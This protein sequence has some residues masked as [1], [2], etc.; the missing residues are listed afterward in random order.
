MLKAV[1]DFRAT[2][3]GR[4]YSGVKG[5]AVKCPP[6]LAQALKEGGIVKEETEKKETKND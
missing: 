2:F 1:K 5:R 6:A 3:N 4:D